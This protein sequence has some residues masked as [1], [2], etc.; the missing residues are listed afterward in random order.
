M[1]LIGCKKIKL[2]SQ[3]KNFFLR[4]KPKQKI[5]KKLQTSCSYPP[6]FYWLGLVFFFFLLIQCRSNFTFWVSSL[7]VPN[8][9][10][11][12]WR[13]QWGLEEISHLRNYLT[14]VFNHS[15]TSQVLKFGQWKQ[16]YLQTV[17][18]GTFEFPRVSKGENIYSHP[19]CQAGRP[20]TMLV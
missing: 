18:Q 14:V 7:P 11:S 13:G 3:W 8:D 17:H 2:K 20:C 12:G 16:M 15:K 10:F 4:K 1:V 19:F 5:D 9:S 6:V